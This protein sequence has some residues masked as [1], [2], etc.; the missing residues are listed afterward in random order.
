MGIAISGGEVLL[1]YLDR[2]PSG[3]W[4][5]KVARKTAGAW[6]IHPIASTTAT[7]ARSVA[8]QTD[9]TGRPYLAYALDGTLWLHDVGNLTCPIGDADC[10]GHD[11]ESDALPLDADEWQDTDGDGVGDGAD[12]DDDDDLVPDVTDNCPLLANAE[13]TDLDNDGIG[14][15]CDSLVD[16]DQ[17][18]IDD[19]RDNCPDQPNPEQR[20]LDGDGLGDACDVCEPCLPSASGWRSTLGD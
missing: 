7:L 8:L 1:A 12:L 9:S 14:D 4:I 2:Q 5:V 3:L 6:Q 19:R 20:D 16:I 15:L 13:Q 17:D 18:G 11:A 10:D